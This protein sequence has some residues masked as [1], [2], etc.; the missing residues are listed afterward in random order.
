MMWKRG[1]YGCHLTATNAEHWTS[2]HLT[3]PAGMGGGLAALGC[4]MG[5]EKGTIYLPPKF[6]AMFVKELKGVLVPSPGG[7]L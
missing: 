4:Y 1:P 3:V 7:R 2:A 5:L 6:Q